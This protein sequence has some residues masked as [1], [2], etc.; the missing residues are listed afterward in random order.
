MVSERY[1]KNVITTTDVNVRISIKCN[2]D[3]IL[4]DI[5]CVHKCTPRF[6]LETMCLTANR[7][8]DEPVLLAEDGYAEPWVGE[9]QFCNQDLKKTVF[10]VCERELFN[11]NHFDDS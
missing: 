11:S 6:V 3:S 5:C 8:D 7:F 9:K 2:T 10:Q 4:E 1:C